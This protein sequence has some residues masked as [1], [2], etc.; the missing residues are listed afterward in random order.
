MKSLLFLTW[1][2]FTCIL[3]AQDDVSGLRVSSQEPLPAR[4]PEFSKWTVSFSAQKS[5]HEAPPLKQLTVTKT[6]TVYHEEAVAATGEKRESW[7]V[8]GVEIVTKPGTH[9]WTILDRNSFGVGAVDTLICPDYSKTDFPGLDW[10]FSNGFQGTQNVT[11]VPC[12]VFKGRGRNSLATPE[13]DANDEKGPG[14]AAI[15]ASAKVHSEDLAYLDAAT[16]LPVCIQTRDEA[17]F[18]QFVT[19]PPVMQT[20][21]PEIQSALEKRTKIRERLI[22]KPPKPF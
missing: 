7:N 15:V 2:A 6:K 5:A 16:R 17:R 14:K 19:I 13:P 3:S 21:P 11:G 4:A 1:F 12:I 10:I 18:Y 22:A 8:N 20:L 9:Q